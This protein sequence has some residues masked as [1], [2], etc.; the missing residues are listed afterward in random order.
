ML[1]EALLHQFEALARS[2]PVLMI[3][4]DAQWIDP[5]SR[6]LLDLTLSRIRRMPVLIVVTFRTEFQHAWSG[7][8]HVTVL[9]LDRLGSGAGEVMVERLR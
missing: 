7:Q 2:R 1:F 8:P 3:Y 6:E 4:E 9:A 5:T